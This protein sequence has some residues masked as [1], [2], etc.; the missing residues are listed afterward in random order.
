MTLNDAIKR[1]K[2]YSHR[3]DQTVTIDTITSDIIIAIN[4]VRRDLVKRIPKRWL[5]VN[6]SVQLAFVQSTSTYSLVS[7]VQEPI[8]FWFTDGGQDFH[9]T[10]VSSDKEW[11]AKFY[12]SQASEDRPRIYRE[13]ITS[14]T[15]QIE[16]FPTP[17]ASYSVNYEYYKFP[18]SDLS[19]S[20]LST[21]LPDI[22]D[23]NHDVIWK[24]G[25]YYYLKA[26]D[27]PGQVMAKQDYL[28]AT[29]ASDISDERDLDE[30]VRFRFDQTSVQNP[31]S[32]YS[33]N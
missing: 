22:P 5:W 2:L 21:A 3:G 14:G 26:F 1:V 32:F 25:L 12:D 9:L 23:Y 19:T 13:R 18:T 11:F 15:K 29:N 6:A 17:D 7:E 20:D 28:E 24:G 30:D 33:Q 10:K 31:D 8:H 27:D 16:V 4:D